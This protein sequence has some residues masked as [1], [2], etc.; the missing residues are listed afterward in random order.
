MI[1]WG[2]DEA[3]GWARAEE[4]DCWEAVWEGGYR[5]RDQEGLVEIGPAYKTASFLN[6]AYN[7]HC[8]VTLHFS[9]GPHRIR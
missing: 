7:I 1:V 4:G 2:G 9:D 8:H 5:A 3:L 6:D